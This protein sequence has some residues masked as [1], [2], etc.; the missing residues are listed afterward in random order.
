[1]S[2][3]SA[4]MMEE[5]EELKSTIEGISSDMNIFWLMFGAILVFCE[6]VL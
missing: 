5:I 2:S 4:A 3:S 1:M 6:Y